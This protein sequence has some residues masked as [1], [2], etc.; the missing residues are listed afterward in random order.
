M[1]GP[2]SKW[3]KS[4]GHPRTIT[5]AHESHPYLAKVSNAGPKPEDKKY[6]ATTKIA[7][8]ANTY[9]T[10]AHKGKGSHTIHVPFY[11][12]FLHGWTCCS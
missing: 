9:H 8:G 3:S 6:D 12:M 4:T 11:R 2:S 10:T 5:A 7:I 1:C